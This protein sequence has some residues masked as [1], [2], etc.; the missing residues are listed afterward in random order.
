[1]KNMLRNFSSDMS[2]GIVVFLVAIP[3][4]LGVAVASGVSELSGIVA[5]VVGGILVGA[6]SGS[7]LSVSGPAAGLTAIVAAAVL[8]LPAIEAF[9]L[10]VVISGVMQII[11]GAFKLGIIGDY[12]PNSVIKGMLAGIGIILIIKQLPYL[13]GYNAPEGGS[14]QAGGGA[15]TAVLEAIKHITPMVMVIGL[16]GLALMVLFDMKWMKSKKIFQILNGPLVVV[17]VAVMLA[18]VTGGLSTDHLVNLPVADN[19]PEFVSLLTFPNWEFLNNPDVWITAVT[20]ALVASLETLLAIEAVDKLDPEKRA[21][22]NNRELMAQGSGNIVSGLLGGL[23]LTSVIVRS[24]ANINS[25]AKSKMSTIIH[26][27]LILVS[28]LFLPAVLNMIPK[29]ALAAV[30]IYTGYKLAKVSLFREYYKKGWHQFMPF[31][32]TLSSIVLTDLLTGVMIGLVLAVFYIIRDNFRSSIYMVK[33]RNNYMLRLRKD[34]SFFSKPVLKKKFAEVPD[35]SVVLID[36]SRAEFVDLDITDTINE[37][38]E[39]AKFRNITVRVS[40]SFSNVPTRMWQQN[41]KNTNGVLH[42]DDAAH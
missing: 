9:F 20:L 41:E 42:Y 29:A 37:F 12:I 17:L 27:L 16:T 31:V 32:V 19:L 30:L 1:M 36:V 39:Q 3:L 6:L 23:P 34:I 15:F 18:T 21:T 38:K 26:G 11:M 4:C 8:K 5:G 33:D 40:G 24:S 22:P 2:S 7:Q 14:A 13:V 10:A 25:G 35:N 28:V